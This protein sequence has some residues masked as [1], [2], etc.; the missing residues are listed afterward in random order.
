MSN[1]HG[2]HAIQSDLGRARG[3]GS[4]HHGFGHWWQQRVTAVANLLLMLWLACA[5]A[6]MPGWT[7]GEFTAWL[8]QPVNAVLMILS[9]ISV[10]F[11]AALGVQVILEDYVGGAA[12][13]VSVTAVRF[14]LFG[15]AALAILSVLK[16]AL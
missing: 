10:F 15:G 9:V 6:S 16:I 3:L 12:R 2:K 1:N 8:A 11:H 4:S 13:V 14:A 5:V 7:H